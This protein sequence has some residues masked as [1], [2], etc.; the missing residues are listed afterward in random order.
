MTVYA[1]PP[2][3]D[4]AAAL[5]AGLDTRHPDPLDLARVTLIVN[6][7]RMER[8]LAAL[9]AAGPPRLLPRIEV[10]TEL[11]PPPGAPPLPEA[12]PPLRQRLRI[13]SLIQ[14]LIARQPGLAPSAALYDLADSL[15]ALMDEMQ[16]EGVTPET[17]ATLDTD[18]QSG[19]WARAQTFF[20]IVAEYLAADE[21]LS[22]DARHAAIVDHLVAAWEETPPRHPIYV[23]GSTGSRGPTHRL[24]CA[25]AQLPGCGVILPGFDHDMPAAVWDE[26]TNA[27]TSEDHPQF[28]Y[29]RLLSH[30]GKTAH[31]V[32]TWTSTASKAAHRTQLLSLALR[33]APVT[34]QWRQEGPALG[35]LTHVLDGVTLLEAPSPR[36]EALAIALR[37]RAAAEDGKTAAL[38]TPDRTLT[39]RVAAALDRWGIIPD[40]SAGQPLHLSPPG[41]FLRHVGTLWQGRLT[42][43][44]LLVLL[45]HPLTHSAGGRNR[46][47][48]LTRDLEIALRRKEVAFPTRAMIRDFADGRG[49]AGWGAWLTTA[50]DTAE[51][52]APDNAARPLQDWV[53]LHIKTAE[54]L[55]QGPSGEDTGELWRENAGIKARRVV[56]TLM[57]EAHLGG[58]LTAAEYTSLHAALLR[59][60]EVRDR[61][62]AHPHVLI[63]GTL[64]ARVQG[65]DTVILAGLNE[66]TW[67]KAPAPDPWLNRTLRHRAGLLLP[68]RQIGLSAHD[69][70]MAA[71]AP[72]VWLTRAARSDD[73]ETVPSRWLNR[74]GN[75]M[76]GLTAQNG[77]EAWKAARARGHLWLDRV[78]ALE[79][80]SPTAPAPRPSPAPPVHVRPRKLRV[81]DI[82]RLR[83]D[84]YAIYARDVL[85]LRKLNPVVRQ[86]DMRERGTLLHTALERF[87]KGG[88]LDTDTLLQI[89]REELHG[90]VPWSSTAT[91][92]T[93][94]MATRAAQFVADER[95]RQETTTP[96]RLE[97][98]GE[99][100]LPTLGVTLR[101]RADRI[102]LTEAGTA[103]IYDYKTGAAPTPAQQLAYD[104]QLLIEAAM[105]ARGAF[106]AVGKR[107]VAGAS[108]LSLNAALKT[109]EAPI[110]ETS[111]DGK[112]KRVTL[113][114]VWEDLET[115]LTR[116]LKPGHGFT[117]RRAAEKDRFEW[118]YD[119]LARFGEWD[120]TT[121][122][123]VQVIT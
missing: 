91:L 33:P 64:E 5:I 57:D 95:A 85:R 67:P 122:A 52:F 94:Q 103:V 89:V 35:D 53:A 30:V 12:C 84:P 44:A 119:H 109:T 62:A 4:F 45:K 98:D 115:L 97:T 88:T 92:W 27:L 79:A 7:R 49:A 100:T 29:A 86:P 108:Y 106:E 70:Q 38:V 40:D 112:T 120:F 117:S 102:D 59:R 17:I 68:D 23:A 2:G 101:G 28:R 82:A 10:I 116:T 51:A 24:M 3:V 14:A 37:L 96:F 121:R 41:R 36:D 87:I 20:G 81:T 83:R 60:E 69:F 76:T 75:L 25:L 118:D 123:D 8:R 34:D 105:V 46:H 61:D 72:E 13:V 42:L 6:T 19:H 107:E 31:E 111:E 18:D 22:A 48:L 73:T 15:I 1:L 90:N 65:A 99:I 71:A 56:D 74:L 78:A 113:D 47:Q 114:Q 32:V 110:G 54:A 55:S 21:T 66:G 50:L 63:W 39:R 80:V 43:E 16:G 11:S 58:T 26:L 93:A 104:R 9:Y 77:P